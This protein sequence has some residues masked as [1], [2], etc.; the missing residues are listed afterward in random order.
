MPISRQL[1]LQPVRCKE[2][3]VSGVLLG[4][5]RWRIPRVVA[6]WKDREVKPDVR[7]LGNAIPLVK[8]EIFEEV[9]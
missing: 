8:I 3:L 2:W 7:I 6:R 4:L 1:L 9:K 5:I